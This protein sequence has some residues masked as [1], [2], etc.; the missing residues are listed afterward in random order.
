MKPSISTSEIQADPFTR[1]ARAW[2]GGFDGPPQESYDPQMEGFSLLTAESVWVSAPRVRKQTSTHGLRV[3][4]AR[5]SPSTNQHRWRATKWL[6]PTTDKYS[7]YA[8]TPWGDKSRATQRY[9]RCDNET[10]GFRR[11]TPR[12]R[13]HRLAEGALQV[14]DQTAVGHVNTNIVRSAEP[15]KPELRQAFLSNNAQPESLA[16]APGACVRVEGKAFQTLTVCQAEREQIRTSGQRGS[17]TKDVHFD[18]FGA[19]SLSKLEPCALLNLRG[20]L[21]SVTE[22]AILCKLGHRRKTSLVKLVAVGSVR[23]GM[24]P[25]CVSS[26]VSSEELLRSGREISRSTSQ[27][28]AKTVRPRGAC[29]GPV[30]NY[31]ADPIML[32]LISDN[33]SDLDADDLRDDEMPLLDIDI[34]YHQPTPYNIFFHENEKGCDNDTQ[35]CASGLDTDDDECADAEEDNDSEC[36][37]RIG[38]YLHQQRSMSPLPYRNVW[39]DQQLRLLDGED[40]LRPQLETDLQAVHQQFIRDVHRYVSHDF[41][42]RMVLSGWHF[43]NDD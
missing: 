14:L 18:P 13:V 2:N 27:A 37:E 7:K 16:R 38:A 28:D 40:T 9:V 30:E 24:L 23:S 11:S 21:A 22:N 1:T 29:V 10:V 26:R 4:A 31:D 8:P 39:T 42:T 5:P 33:D 19:E 32:D 34:V 25:H 20:A 36:K 3:Q 35:G 43:E 17:K 15:S 12:H 41:K 6:P